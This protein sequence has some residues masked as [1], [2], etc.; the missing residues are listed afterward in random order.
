MGMTASEAKAAREK[1]FAAIR[2]NAL[3]LEQAAEILASAYEIEEGRRHPSRDPVTGKL[4][5]S[6][7]QHETCRIVAIMLKSKHPPL[8]AALGGGAPDARTTKIEA[9]W[10]GILD[11]LVS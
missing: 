5:M 6:M 3:P 8:V 4:D 7:W 11:Q 1:M 9:R 2:A 10:P